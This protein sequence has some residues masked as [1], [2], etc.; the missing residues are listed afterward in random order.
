MVLR[1]NGKQFLWGKV[2][3]SHNWVGAGNA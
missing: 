2:P 3:T 1:H